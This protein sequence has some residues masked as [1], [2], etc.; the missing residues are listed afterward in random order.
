MTSPT[1]RIVS[2][3]DWAAFREQAREVFSPEALQARDLP[4][5]LLPYQANAV[6]ELDVHRVIAVEK[7]RRIGM[8]WGIGAA[9]VL[10]A[11]TTRSDGGMNVFY[12]GYNQEMAREFIAVCGMW[13]KAFS[14]AASDVEEV[15]FYDQE[16]DKYI[17]TFRI[18]FASGFYIQA[19]P[20]SP[21]SL[22]GMQGLVI[23]D[24]A[25]FHDDLKEV[26]KA[27][28]A[29]LMWGGQVL[30]IST[31]D[32]EENPFNELLNEI[33]SGKRKGKVL[34]ISFDDALKDGLYERICLVTGE[35]YSVEAEAA[36][37]EEI[38]AFYGDDADEELDVIP[39]KG[40]GVFLPRAL[41]ESLCTDVPVIRRTFDDMYIFRPEE[42]R[43]ADCLG[44]CEEELGPLLRTLSPDARQY[45]GADVARRSD[46]TS[47]WPIE[48]DAKLFRKCPFVVELRNAP[49]DQQKQIFYYIVSRFP[50]FMAGKIDATGM[51]ADMAEWAAT[52]FGFERIEQ[53]TLSQAWYLDNMTRF[54]SGFEDRM[55]SLPKD[56]LIVEDHRAIKKVRGVP[57]VPERTGKGK[58]KRHGDTAIAH[59]LAY[60]ATYSEVYQPLVYIPITAQ[61]SENRAV[62]ITSGIRA[63][64]GL[65]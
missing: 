3:K 21:R 39:S 63:G 45:V 42:V 54:K 31:H 50:K 19:L 48:L 37:R 20:S 34:R 25:A 59:A 64:K 52:K 14:E 62:R 32:G 36:W 16:G 5:V 7:S 27:A 46:L 2:K 38:Y 9:A 41:V 1:G 22:R 61:H 29:L 56:T 35:T 18:T 28:M 6:E 11:A 30:I 40:S 53:V 60:A 33:R 10:R 49:F 47:F 26:I 51:G 8:T 24:E 65:F 44:W 43:A 57:C 4:S 23:L 17:R 15:M 55:L 13:A 58:D 12:M